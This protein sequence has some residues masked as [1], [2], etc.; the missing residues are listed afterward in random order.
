MNR[1]DS[2]TLIAGIMNPEDRLDQIMNSCRF[3]AESKLDNVGI[4]M[5]LLTACTFIVRLEYHGYHAKVVRK[6]LLDMDK[7]GSIDLSAAPYT[8][9]ELYES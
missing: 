2:M 3:L 8:D 9:D 1:E 6:A 5:A 7:H 4:H